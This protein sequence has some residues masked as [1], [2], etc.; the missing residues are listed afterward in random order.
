MS[1][2][3]KYT[4]K[5]HIS[6]S[7]DIH[8][9]E[10]GQIWLRIAVGDTGKGIKQED[11]GKL[12]NDFVQVDT[13]KNR[14]IEGT[15]LGLAITKRLCILMGGDV[16][17]QSEYGKGS[18]FTVI[19][20]Q[21]IASMEPFAAVE[22][23]SN[24]KVL[25][26]DGRAVYAQSVRWSLDN[27]GVPCTITE[28]LGDF[29]RVI[30]QGEWYYIF[31]GYGLYEKIKP[32]MDRPDDAFPGGKKPP[33]AL[34]VEWGTETHIPGACFMFLPI[35]SLTIANLLN[36]RADSEGFSEGSASSDLV[37]FTIPR[38]R[39]LIVD[40]I[41]TNL[42]VAE[43]LLMA[44]QAT[45]DICQSGAE[46]IDLVKKQEYDIVFMDHMMPDMDGIETT[47]AIRALWG[48]R[49]KTMP[50][51][52]LTANA[53]VGMREMFIEKGFNDFLA[54]P[55]DISKMEEI[56]I[57]WVPKEKRV[58]DSGQL[59]V[60][61][62]QE[63][64][65]NAGED[66][67]SIPGVDS[68]RGIAM[69]GGTLTAYKQVL[70]LFR[71]DARDRLPLLQNVPDENVLPAFITQ[72][73]ALK[74][75]SASLGAAEISSQAAELEVAGKAKDMAFIRN[76]LDYFAGHLEE[77][78]N[79]ISD[80]L[81]ADTV[82]AGVSMGKDSE[83]EPPANISEYVPLLHELAIALV[84]RKAD[85]ID[86]VLENLTRQILDKKS[87]EILDQISDEVL[88]AEY[89]KAWEMVF[90]LLK[91]EKENVN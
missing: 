5:G 91:G 18:V 48:G 74:S 3:V 58:V 19:V 29:A 39:L 56:L 1:N 7:I 11:R 53:M 14:G 63:A 9:Q 45:V 16:G 85:D 60:G 38:A 21:N 35:Q 90:L 78:I 59:V 64:E 83:A 81:E 66:A 41:A 24:K 34:M 37:H 72:V 50:I 67:L 12:F 43:G 23:A 4:E 54:K 84:E 10:H 33:L 65:N 22:N 13:K 69:T 68:A 86:H 40:D 44:Y 47:T 30:L 25:V 87:K 55:I 80:V 20:P 36:G 77:L 42:R 32:I 89:D 46:A 71:K 82:T 75:A 61:S 57:R 49:F 15:G 62:G 73:H 27:L 26:Y 17:I 6:L 2:A 51:V 76:N 70:S 28:T 8:K 31:A 88:M 79:H 52:A